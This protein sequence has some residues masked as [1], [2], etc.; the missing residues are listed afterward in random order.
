MPKYV[1][2]IAHVLIVSTIITACSAEEESTSKFTVVDKLRTEEIYRS[3]KIAVPH[4]ITYI[5]GYLVMRDA[6]GPPFI[7]SYSLSSKELHSFGERGQGPHSFMGVWEIDNLHGKEEFRAYDFMTR[8]VFRCSVEK[9]KN[10][11]PD[12]CHLEFTLNG[13]GTPLRVHLGVDSSIIATGLYEKRLAFYDST[14]EQYKMV[15]STPNKVDVK[16]EISHVRRN[17]A[18]AGDLQ[19]DPAG[20]RIALASRR[21]DRIDIY[22][23]KG[24][25]LATAIGGEG[26]A[27][28]F[29]II[30]T[31]NLAPNADTRTAFT[32]ISATANFIY[33]L[34]DG[35]KKSEEGKEA[36]RSVVKVFDWSGEPIREIYTDRQLTSISVTSDD[37]VAY[38][39]S[40]YPA[41]SIVS[42]EIR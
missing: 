17:R 34:Y 42:F 24:N 35:R 36:H 33:A 8:R 6:D 2:L 37:S 30:R 19:V 23:N 10:M 39:T 1:G 22:D 14:G 25:S 26:Y 31:G 38:A 13:T 9:M 20:E 7:H 32:D 21:A 11:V 40:T 12:T 3:D 27:P 5:D 4:D 41:P 16:G 29:R 15:G 18:Y 28:T